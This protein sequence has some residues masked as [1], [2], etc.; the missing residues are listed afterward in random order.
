MSDTRA[1]AF[2]RLI[3]GL[4]LR[5]DDREVG[6]YTAGYGGRTVGISFGA[7]VGAKALKLRALGVS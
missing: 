7:M 5:G 4:G 3:L 2:Q 6:V 1:S